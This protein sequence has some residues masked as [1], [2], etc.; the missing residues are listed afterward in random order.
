[1][2]RGHAPVRRNEQRSPSVD[3]SPRSPSAAG[4]NCDKS[5]GVTRDGPGHG[6]GRVGALQAF[7]GPLEMSVVAGTRTGRGRRHIATSRVCERTRL[8]ELGLV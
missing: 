2:L 4:T 6:A 8:L 1:M 5:V 7:R 3:M